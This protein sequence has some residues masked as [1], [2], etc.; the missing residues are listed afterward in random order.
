MPVF[1]IGERIATPVCGLVRN[2]VVVMMVQTEL[3]DKSEFERQLPRQED[4][5]GF[6]FLKI[7]LKDQFQNITV[8]ITVPC[9]N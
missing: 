8:F 6:I 4:R 5:I 7:F 9:Y 1:Q 2:D 3:F